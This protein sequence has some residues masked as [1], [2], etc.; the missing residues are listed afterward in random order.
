M[1]DA[2]ETTSDEITPKKSSGKIFLQELEEGLDAMRLGAWR[3]AISG[4]AGGMELGLSLLFIAIWRTISLDQL[5]TPVIEL[6][7][8]AM[9]SFGFIAV[10]LGRSELFTEQTTLAILPLLSGNVSVKEV[11]RLWGIVY[12]TNLIGAAFS[13]IFIAWI[14]V[15]LGDIDKKVLSEIA[16]RIVRHPA[17]TIL[18]SAVLAGWLMGLLSWLVAAARDTISQIV[19]IAIFTSAIGLGRLHHSILGTA[20]V[21]GGIFAG[22]GITTDDLC[23]FLLWSTLGNAVGGGCFVAI[24]KFGHARPE[25]NANA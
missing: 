14:G 23:F 22:S 5:S 10:M 16:E 25:D 8:A 1:P 20:E 9:S 15:A 18:F 12:I 11:T 7:A 4:F 6:L 2:V 3:L 21:L 13:A 24:L 17:A 19:V